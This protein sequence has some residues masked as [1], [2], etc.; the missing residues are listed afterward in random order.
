[1]SLSGTGRSILGVAQVALLPDTEPRFGNELSRLEQLAIEVGVGPDELRLVIRKLIA[2]KCGWATPR[3][4]VTCSVCGNTFERSARRVRAAAAEGTGHR[5]RH[6]AR[7][8]E[9]GPPEFAWI[10]A[11]PPEVREQ[12]VAALASLAA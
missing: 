9:P 6:C 2:K 12:A 10:A 11:L 3:R 1:M 7:D 5:C 4:L 8:M